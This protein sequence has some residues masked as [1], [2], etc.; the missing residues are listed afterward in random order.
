MQDSTTDEECS[1]AP[2]TP[3]PVLRQR[4]VAAVMWEGGGGGGGGVA[5][6]RLQGITFTVK[7]RLSTLP[8]DIRISVLTTDRVIDLKRRLHELHSVDPQRIT[9]LYS[10]RVLRNNTVL[11]RLN[12]PKGYVIQ[13][14][15]S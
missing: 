12:V 2:S 11:K 4:G 5:A 7:V 6:T 10:G 1:A 15:V 14:I 8:K 13:A 9:M 3:S